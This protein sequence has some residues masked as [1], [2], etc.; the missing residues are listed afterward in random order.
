M[1][2]AEKYKPKKINNNSRNDDMMFTTFKTNFDM[3]INSPLLGWLPI[4]FYPNN[5]NIP[6][7]NIM[8]QL[9]NNNLNIPSEN[10]NMNFYNDNANDD[11]LYSYNKDSAPQNNNSNPSS[12]GN[13]NM[14]YYSSNTPFYSN[15][16]NNPP[17]IFDCLKDFDLDI[18]RD[19]DTLRNDIDDYIEEIFNNIESNNPKTFALLNAYAV[20]Y[21]IQ[22]LLI[23]RI[24]RF[25]VDYTS[26]NKGEKNV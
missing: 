2:P 16:L 6:P 3:K 26:K 18:D 9:L 24:I 22:K 21:P 1:I 19:I 8:P 20:P 11:I 17:R 12:M 14:G 5:M 25:T 15:A 7:L 23:K 10:S 13:I 4:Y